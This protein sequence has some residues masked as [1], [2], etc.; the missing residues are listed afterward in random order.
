[1]AHQPQ[2]V[3]DLTPVERLLAI[4]AWSAVAVTRLLGDCFKWTWYLSIE[5]HLTV[6]TATFNVCGKSSLD[7]EHI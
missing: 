5:R 7:N 3:K 6:W 1:M 2:P 4:T